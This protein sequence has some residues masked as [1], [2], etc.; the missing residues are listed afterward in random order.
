MPTPVLVLWSD[1]AGHGLAD[2]LVHEGASRAFGVPEHAV[3]VLRLCPAC[4]SSAHGRPLLAPVPRLALPHVSIGHAGAVTVVALSSAGPIGVDVESSDAAAFDTFPAVALHP[5]EKAGST[6]ER[7]VTWV[8]KEALLKATGHG[9]VVD[10][11]R[12]CLTEPGDP[13]VLIEWP[14]PGPPPSAQLYDVETAP[15][16]VA[17]VAV[18][19]P[20]PLSIVVRKAGPVA[21]SPRATR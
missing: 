2:P 15:G 12:I 21:R 20:A 16:H 8:R 1:H 3:R 5:A 6:R 13:P 4:G 19:G 9:L 17:A 14:L 10:P 11:A 7:T 18:M